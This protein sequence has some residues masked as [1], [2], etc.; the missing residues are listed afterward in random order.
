[1]YANA[2][3]HNVSL[4]LRLSRP[5]CQR[6]SLPG[7]PQSRCDWWRRVLTPPPG[8]PGTAGA[9]DRWW[10]AW[11]TLGGSG[12]MPGTRLVREM[13]RQRIKSELTVV[14]LVYYQCSQYLEFSFREDQ[15][16][17]IFKL[18]VT[19]EAILLHHKNSTKIQ[20]SCCLKWAT[21]GESNVNILWEFKKR[22]IKK[23]I[24]ILITHFQI[25]IV[26]L[27]LYF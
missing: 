27:F 7:C 23:T 2:L 16:R 11:H 25:H 22:R 20:Q 5:F 4:C 14:Y 13:E 26:F 24:Q 15:I 10:T 18:S 6:C 12:Q 17:T 1:M 3:E 9:P 8:G 21:F 19:K